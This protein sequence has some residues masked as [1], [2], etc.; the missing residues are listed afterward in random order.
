MLCPTLS[1]TLCNHSELEYTLG[2]RALALTLANI[3]ALPV[4]DE[5]HAKVWPIAKR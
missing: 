4:A 1:P 2:M 5:A 3:E